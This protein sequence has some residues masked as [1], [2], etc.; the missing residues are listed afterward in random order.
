L[1]EACYRSIAEKRVVRLSEVVEESAG[2]WEDV[3]PVL[4]L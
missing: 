3:N 2:S 4:Q 1:I